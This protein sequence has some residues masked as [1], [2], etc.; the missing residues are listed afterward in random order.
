[1]PARASASSSARAPRTSPSTSPPSYLSPL[2]SLWGPAVPGCTF[3][4]FHLEG[5]PSEAARLLFGSR[6]VNLPYADGFAA[7]LA[8]HLKASLATSD[9]D[10]AIIEKKLDI[11]WTR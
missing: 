1:M 8:A 9:K 5:R 4:H 11:F 6:G 10:F 3:F 2:L 7:A